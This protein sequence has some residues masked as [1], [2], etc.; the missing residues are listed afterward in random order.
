MAVSYIQCN[1]VISYSTINMTR[2]HLLSM[3][4][5]SCKCLLMVYTCR[6]GQAC[7]IKASQTTQQIER[8]GHWARYVQA[9]PSMPGSD[10]NNEINIQNCCRLHLPHYATKLFLMPR[11]V[12]FH[13]GC[14]GTQKNAK[15]YTIHHDGSTMATTR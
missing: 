8:A 15:Y 9:V 12:S 4:T 7:D 6:V 13:Y 14:R 2:R 5:W 11:P 3:S 1:I 10:I